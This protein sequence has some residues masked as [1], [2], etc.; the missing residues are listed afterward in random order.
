MPTIYGRLVKITAQKKLMVRVTTKTY[1]RI[2]DVAN[3]AAKNAFD[4]TLRGI[5]TPEFSLQSDNG[6]WSYFCMVSLDK[7]DKQLMERKFEPLLKKDVCIT[8]KTA[9]YEFT[10]EKEKVI[11]G[12]NLVL[13]G[14]YKIG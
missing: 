3:D 4:G 1:D 5:K 9:T 11:Q 6:E 13:T 14:I 12:V 2:E 8:Y 10:A 7:Y